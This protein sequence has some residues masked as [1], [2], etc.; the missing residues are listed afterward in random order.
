MDSDESETLEPRRGPGRQVSTRI[1][2]VD[3]HGPVAIDLV[4]VL[5]EP[6]QRMVDS[7]GQVILRVLLGRQH[8]IS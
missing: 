2:A 1:P 3:D 6:S 5:F 7:P 8:L 4:R